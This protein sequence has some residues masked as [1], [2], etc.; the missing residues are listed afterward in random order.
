MGTRR[1]RLSWADTVHLGQ[2][3]AGTV[4]R[5][6]SCARRSAPSQAAPGSDRATGRP[7]TASGAFERGASEVADCI[8]SEPP[9]LSPKRSN[10][11]SP[12]ESSPTCTRR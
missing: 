11:L 10:F 4:K 6:P 9:G 1:S 2:R 8:A 12:L 7:A 5:P 3:N